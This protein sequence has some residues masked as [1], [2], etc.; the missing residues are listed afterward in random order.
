MATHFNP[1]SCLSLAA[2]PICVAMAGLVATD[3]TLCV[4]TPSAWPLSGMATM[5]LLMAVFHLP[6]W[7]R[8]MRSSGG[9]GHI[10]LQEE[11]K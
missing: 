4:G 8:L 1:A 5:Y 11:R 6:P 7:L 2:S 3:Q 10:T 9:A